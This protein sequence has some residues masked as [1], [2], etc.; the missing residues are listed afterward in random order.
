LL[1]K[2]SSN[3]DE[4]KSDNDN[5]TNLAA[6]RSLGDPNNDD[7]DRPVSNDDFDKLFAS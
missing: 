3:T 4:G 1:D 7:A 2:E 6:E 5:P